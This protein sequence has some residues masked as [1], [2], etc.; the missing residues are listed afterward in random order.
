MFGN[1]SNTCCNT[2]RSKIMPIDRLLFIVIDLGLIVCLM[3]LEKGM[4]DITSLI[5]RIKA[6][7]KLKG[8]K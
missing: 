2:A 4:R 1:S 5:W 3:L 8:Y 7:N 6:A